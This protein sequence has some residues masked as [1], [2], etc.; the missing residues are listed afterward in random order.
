MTD[1]LFPELL[2]ALR[3]TLNGSDQDD[4]FRRQFQRLVANAY[5]NNA[6]RRDVERLLDAIDLDVIDEH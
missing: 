6:E 4:Q 3:E 1:E 2:E 5:Q